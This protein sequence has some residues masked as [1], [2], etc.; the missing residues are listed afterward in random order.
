MARRRP[1]PQRA[2][3]KKRGLA[4]GTPVYTG[5]VTEGP[6]V[7]HVLDFDGD[8]VRELTD[9]PFAEVRPFR[10]S[11]STTWID[12]HGLHDTAA[13][14]TLCR[15][16]GLHPL[17]V[18]DVLSVEGRAKADDY[19]ETVFITAKMASFEGDPAHARLHLEH[20]ALVL[21]DH[22]VL[23]FQERPGDPFEPVR[24]R[25]RAGSGRVRTLGADYLLHVLL[26]A[27]VDGYFVALVALEDRVD[28][29]EDDVFEGRNA[30][31]EQA[32]HELRGEIL[33]FRRAAAP[34]RVAI[35]GL[36][37][38]GSPR[39]TPEV[40]LYLR[41]VLD[42]LD[43]VLDRLDGTRER[44]TSVLEVHLAANS[45]KM[46]E[47]MRGLTVVAT[48]FIPLTFVAGVYGM[49]FDWMPELRWGWGYPAAMGLMAVM[50]GV[51]LVFMRWRRWI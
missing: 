13:I 15:H 39:V 4:P 2:H 7:A 32:V 50:A 34:L 6:T 30:R 45:H 42:H 23:S 29:L 36:Q 49:N 35:S 40:R 9:A 37:R 41:D 44:L 17:A 27:I 10:D 48:V 19:G 3:A 14:E 11:P 20:V 33:M 16:F 28:V 26:D 8:G 25:I 47:V 24:K 21:G 51:M 1:R 31:P 46:N 22:W 5:D 18:E 38:D 43:L 12:L